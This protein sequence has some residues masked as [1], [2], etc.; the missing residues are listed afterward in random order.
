MIMRASVKQAHF[1]PNVRHFFLPWRS[2]PM[3]RHFTKAPA[4]WDMNRFVSLWRWSAK[5]SS[6]SQVI[7]NWSVILKADLC[8]V[9]WSDFHSE[10]SRSHP[11]FSYDFIKKNLRSSESCIVINPRNPRKPKNMGPHNCAICDGN[12]EM[13]FAGT[14]SEPSRPRKNLSA[15]LLTV[16]KRE[17][18]FAS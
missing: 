16:P 11:T 18:A 13:K 4:D 17:K 9:K 8:S 5:I 14:C 10:N 1:S 12:L 7:R 3:R 15:L 2:L 6:R